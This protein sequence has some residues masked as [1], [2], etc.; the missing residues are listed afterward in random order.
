MIDHVDRNVQ[1]LLHMIEGIKRLKIMFADVSKEDFL[2]DLRL[3]GASAFDIST[4]G[5]AAAHVS[6][7]FQLAHPEIP[8]I[9]LRGIRNR[10]VHI[11]DYEQINY[12]IIWTVATVELMEL[13]PKIR[14]A[15]A[16][17]PLPDDFTLPEV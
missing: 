7:E 8:W 9:K 1:R 13:E 17:I 2:E 10:L 14:E 15:L 5:E 16:T 12:D 11:F 3:Q 4:I 6:E